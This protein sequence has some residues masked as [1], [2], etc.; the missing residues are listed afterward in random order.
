MNNFNIKEFLRYS[1]KNNLPT[2]L[3]WIIGL[4]ATIAETDFENKFFIIKD[5]EFYGKTEEGNLLLVKNYTKP[6][7]LSSDAIDVEKGFICNIDNNITTTYGRLVM[8]YL[9]GCY[10]FNGKIKFINEKF[11][12]KDI[13]K[14]Y[15]TKLLTDD[16]NST[17]GITVDEFK[18]FLDVGLYIES[19]SKYL[20]IA[21]TEKSALPPKGLDKF[22]K[23]TLKLMKDKYGEDFA[24]NPIAIAELE[25]LMLDF[26]DG[27]LKDDPAYGK[28]MSGKVT[29]M[30]RKK[31][32]LVFGI[33]N[34]FE[35]SPDGILDS[36]QEGWDLDPK[37]LTAYA[38]DS[39]SG[40]Y[41]RG[42][43]TSQGGVMAKVSLRATSDIKI[44]K[45]DCGTKMGRPVLI[46]A[47][48]YSRYIKRYMIGA[49][50]KPEPLTE[51]KL[52]SLVNKIIYLRT[53]LYCHLDT[54]YCSTCAGENI[55]DYENGVSL[56]VS[57]AS[58]KVLDISL[59]AFHGNSLTIGTLDLSTIH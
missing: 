3:N 44:E 51:E 4:F 37:K 2:E 9:I 47:E 22:K 38:N 29:N 20:S 13:E 35:E 39:R 7:L 54:N 5:K 30:A 52:K 59:K 53:P 24:K 42:K 21:I 33:G 15:V 32:F 25:K 46:T 17:D 18:E 11:T 16:A 27:Y 1:F 58:G 49:N 45:T 40:S 41:G 10:A 36:L 55:S 57:G 6:V 23:D 14:K 19:F 56:L 50:G 28:L 48:N 12:I 8:N 31:M 26:D 43:E 34:S